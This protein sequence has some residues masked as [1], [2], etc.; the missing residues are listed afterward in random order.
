MPSIIIADVKEFD[1][2]GWDPEKMMEQKQIT[3]YCEK[4]GAFGGP[5]GG[6]FL[7]TTEREF[8]REKFYEE[9]KENEKL[10]IEMGGYEHILQK[11]GQELKRYLEGD[12]KIMKDNKKL[13][14]EN[15]ELK[16]ELEKMKAFINELKINVVKKD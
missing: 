13:K 9:R 10:K 6:H 15:K 7:T 4:K 14:K 3:E 2:A 1:K 8:Y 11:Q 16:E 5:G 12:Y